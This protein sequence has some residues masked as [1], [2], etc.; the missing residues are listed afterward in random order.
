MERKFIK[1]ITHNWLVKLI[2][3]IAAVLFWFYYNYEKLPEKYFSV[4]LNAK[5]IPKALA[6]AESY[7]NTV[8]VKIR[9]SEEALQGINAR[10]FEVELDLSQSI[11]GNNNFPVRVNL[12]KKVKKVKIVSTDPREITIKLDR[13]TL[14]EVPVSIT[15]INSPVEGYIKIGESFYPKTAIVRGPDSIISKLNVVR[16]KPIDIGGVM[17]SIYRKEVELDLPAGLLSTHSYKKIKVT[18]NIKKN[19]KIEHF[20]SI[21]IVMKN[22]K[23]GLKIKNIKDMH[24]YAKIEGPAERLATLKKELNFLYIDLS[25]IKKKGSYYKKVRYKIPWNCKILKLDAD[26]KKIKIEEK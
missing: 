6:I 21:T 22:L 9:G 5:N 23:K 11:I 13:L 4:P 10:D 19:Y 15:I 17:G 25:N 16:T 12:I 20:S 14:K 3:L 2:S 18:I 7:Q 8:T 24:S 26:T 1:K